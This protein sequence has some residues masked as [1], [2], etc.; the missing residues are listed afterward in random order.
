MNIVTIDPSLSCTAICVN[1]RM[2][3]Y[4]TNPTA[5]NKPTKKNP[6]GTM[7]KWFTDMEPYVEAYRFFEPTDKKLP[8]SRREFAKLALYN[9]M[10][11]TMIQDIY[12]N[13]QPGNNPTIVCI[14]GYSYASTSNTLIDLVTFSTLLR[15]KLILD[16][17]YTGVVLSPPSLKL[18]ACLLTYPEE[19][20]NEKGKKLPFSN[21]EGISGG[22]FTKHDMMKALL[23]NDTLLDDW[24]VNF[25]RNDCQEEL[26]GK[27]TIPKPVEDVNDARLMHE[28]LCKLARKHNYDI[29]KIE[30]ALVT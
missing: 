25:L 15:S 8:Y 1:G 14:E 17:R 26:M 6:E 9:K 4:A 23:D 24:Y 11:D 2:F 29:A 12:N 10:T 27:K 16:R 30:T 21:H 7:K 22:K 5:R 18:K 19:K 28:I 3:V 20:F 13:L